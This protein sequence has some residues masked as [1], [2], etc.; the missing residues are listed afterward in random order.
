MADRPRAKSLSNATDDVM[1]RRPTGLVDDENA[2]R[3]LWALGLHV[4]AYSSACAIRAVTR[5]SR[6][7]RAAAPAHLRSVIS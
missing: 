4:G 6:V 3:H 2:M 5:L 1:A 7:T